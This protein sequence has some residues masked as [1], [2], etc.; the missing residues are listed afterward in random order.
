MVSGDALRLDVVAKDLPVALAPPLPVTHSP[1]P[2]SQTWLLRA[3]TD[4]A[5]AMVANQA[6]THAARAAPLLYP[7]RQQHAAYD[8]RP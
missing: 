2:R 4:A 3:G 6:P 8:A 5:L 7:T 1:L